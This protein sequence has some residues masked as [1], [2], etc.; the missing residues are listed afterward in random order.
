MSL[1]VSSPHVPVP[2]LVTATWNF[3]RSLARPKI[4]TDCSFPF[5]FSDS[6]FEEYFSFNETNDTDLQSSIITDNIINGERNH[7]PKVLVLNAR[8]MQSKVFDLQPLLL[9]DS[10]DIIVLTETWLDGI[11][12]DCELNFDCY[13]VFRKDRCNRRGGGVLFAVRDCIIILLK[14]QP[15]E[16]QAKSWK[17]QNLKVKK[18]RVS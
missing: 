5:D 17:K 13:N 1:T 16:P 18:I 8:N 3:A 6:F 14:A 4:C 10:F 11:Y 15:S 12:R 9:T 2:L 7:F